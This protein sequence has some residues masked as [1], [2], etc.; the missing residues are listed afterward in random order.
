MIRGGEGA[1]NINAGDG[2]DVIVV[3]GTTTANQ[4]DAASITNP[5]G[6]GV[7]LS[8][9]ITLADLN[10]RSVS[11]VTTGEVIDGGAGNNTLYIY[12]TVDLTGV[13]L[14]NVTQLIV[15]SDVTLTAAQIAQFTTI[16]GDGNSVINIV[17]PEGSGE[18]ILD[19]SMIDVSDIGSLNITGNLTIKIS[20]MADL[21]GISAIV[22]GTA[23]FVTLDII[24]A[25]DDVIIGSAELLTKFNHIAAINLGD[26]A[27]LSID[28]TINIDDL[29]LQVISGTGN[30]ITNGS[31]YMLNALEALDVASGIVM[32][33]NHTPYMINASGEM[34]NSTTSG[35]QTAPSVGNS[36]ATVMSSYG[37]VLH[38]MEIA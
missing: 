25:T 8:S 30:I 34:V 7:D 29:A 33:D 16:D 19:L 14:T 3:V 2:D 26:K 20:D 27:T 38:P 6:S 36:P 15:N 11:E 28:S 10:G 35:L 4:Y 13:T 17:V 37:K 21:E 18:V 24:S 12:G 5:A 32:N 23:D 1:D 9:L 22:V 31:T